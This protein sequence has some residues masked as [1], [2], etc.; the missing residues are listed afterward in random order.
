MGN[1]RGVISDC[2]YVLITLGPLPITPKG[3]RIIIVLKGINK[4]C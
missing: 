3:E 4:T 2:R 1:E